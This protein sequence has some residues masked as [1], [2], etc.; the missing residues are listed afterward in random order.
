MLFYSA[1]YHHLIYLT[2]ET[3]RYP[4]LYFAGEQTEMQK[5]T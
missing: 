4:Y 2:L 3:E 5:V 1:L